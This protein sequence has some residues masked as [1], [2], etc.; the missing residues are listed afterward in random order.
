LPP[1]DELSDE[2]AVTMPREFD[3]DR[4]RFFGTEDKL[5]SSVVPRGKLLFALIVN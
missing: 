1:K 3:G 5:V 2:I 4:Q